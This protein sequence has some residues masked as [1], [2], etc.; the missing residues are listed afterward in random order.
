MDS[1]FIHDLRIHTCIGAYA[2][3]RERPRELLL[4]IELGANTQPAALSDQLHDTVD[5][6]AVAGRIS[7]FAAAHSCQ[8]LETFGERIA[9]ILQTEFSITWLRLTLRKPGAVANT[10]EVGIIIERGHR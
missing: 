4:N 2:W 8:L 1:I 7:E 9:G 5:Y 6:Q 3:E 10:H